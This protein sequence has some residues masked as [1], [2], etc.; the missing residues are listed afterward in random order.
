MPYPLMYVPDSQ[1]GIAQAEIAAK[2]AMAQAQ[3][4]QQASENALRSSL[5]TTAVNAED[6][7]A[8]RMLQA[9]EREA[10]R[11]DALESNRMSLHLQDSN[12]NRQAELDKVRL[13]HQLTMQDRE[14]DP[15]VQA[16]RQELASWGMLSPEE[17]K[18][19]VLGAHPIMSAWEKEQARLKELEIKDKVR[20]E[21][22]RQ[23]ERDDQM[24]LN[25][26]KGETKEDKDRLAAFNNAMQK[27]SMHLS[28]MGQSGKVD[29]SLNPML[30][31]LRSTTS[32][33]MLESFVGATHQSMIGNPSIPYQLRDKYM[34]A[35]SEEFPK[36]RQAIEQ[37]RAELAS[38]R[39]PLLQQELGRQLQDMERAYGVASTRYNEMRSKLYT[40]EALKKSEEG[41][42]TLTMQEGRMPAQGITGQDVKDAGLEY[43]SYAAEGVGGA[44][45]AKGASEWWK[46]Y[47]MT[48]QQRA[49][50]DYLKSV[51]EPNYKR[52][53]VNIVEE[54]PVKRMRTSTFDKTW[55]KAK[56]AQEKTWAGLSK[57][58][59]GKLGVGALAL[60][61]G[62]GLGS[63][64][65]AETSGTGLPPGS[66]DWSP[67]KK[68]RYMQWLKGASEEGMEEGPLT[69]WE[70]LTAMYEY[71]PTT[72]VKRGLLEGLTGRRG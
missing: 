34:Y 14:S 12:A 48:P 41:A 62:L 22:I 21:A 16:A 20:Q 52:N 66:E 23:R 25:L 59:K 70:A 35:I 17:Q 50:E 65:R 71:L 55:R 57:G 7:R 69:P 38:A 42:K 49:Q 51:K 19:K 67:E 64:A 44:M 61:L 13:Q 40:P 37:K 43:G 28:K 8:E 47:T 4:F 31:M 9:Q 3:L 1:A 63:K 15:R 58:G 24:L 54:E 36:Y 56:V 33:G 5:S 6:R 32:F 11:R 68:M 39:H 72:M 30:A 18:A 45:A 10:A 2:M 60:A 29:E 27:N 26:M 53:A 46:R